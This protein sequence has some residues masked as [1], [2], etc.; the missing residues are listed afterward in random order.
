MV[1]LEEIKKIL[2]DDLLQYLTDE[3]DTGL[4]DDD[5]LQEIIDNANE[6][7]AYKLPKAPEA[8]RDEAARN[9]VISRL[10]A[11][12]GNVDMA[13]T[14]MEMWR[15]EMESYYTEMRTRVLEQQVTPS[16]TSKVV[17]HSNE[18]VFTDEELKS[19]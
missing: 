16:D 15:T 10:Y 14:F 2:P 3:L 6:Y 9:Y 5:K 11:Y 1:T 12:V 8:V 4:I 18:R 17:I 7:F 19:W 13:D